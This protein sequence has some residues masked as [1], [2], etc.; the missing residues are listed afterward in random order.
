MNNIKQ[1][2]LKVP[3]PQEIL[4][5]YRRG[6]GDFTGGRLLSRADS[7]PNRPNVVSG[8]SGGRADRISLNYACHSPRSLKLCQNK[9]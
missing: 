6:N 7:L 3:L 2:R 1:H 8:E 9:K 5:N 4:I